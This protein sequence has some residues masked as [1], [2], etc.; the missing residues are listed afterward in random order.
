MNRT[1]LAAF[2]ANRTK[3]WRSVPLTLRN[4]H[5]SYPPAETIVD[6]SGVYVF[7]D[8][9]TYPDML[10]YTV[11]L[12]DDYQEG[13]NVYIALLWQ[14]QDKTAGNVYWGYSHQWAN[15]SQAFPSDSL[16]YVADANL[17]S[18]L[19]QLNIAYFAAINGAGKQV[20]STIKGQIL[21]NSPS[22]T[23]TYNSKQAYL[24]DALLIYPSDKPMA[25]YN[26]K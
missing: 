9:A 15:Q 16:K 12:P 10:Y 7:Y 13:G 21:R 1:Q 22:A 6:N 20:R 18:D 25:A 4:W 24:F 26:S 14:G 8:E 5:A 19:K 17:E 23:D 3:G 2:I 11:P